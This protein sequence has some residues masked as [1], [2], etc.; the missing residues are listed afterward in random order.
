MNEHPQA[1]RMRYAATVDMGL[2]GEAAELALLVDITPEETNA[3]FL[4]RG[5]AIEWQPDDFEQF[6]A[7]PPGRFDPRVLQQTTWWVDVLRRPHRIADRE[8][9]TDDHLVAVIG[10]LRREGWRWAEVDD[11]RWVALL[12]CATE[13]DLADELLDRTPLMQALLAEAKRRDVS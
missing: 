3:H 1:L 12:G 5:A 6:A 9:F 2:R 8:D 4:A 7:L 11:A 10:M 13:G